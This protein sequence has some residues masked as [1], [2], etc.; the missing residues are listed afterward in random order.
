MTEALLMIGLVAMFLAWVWASGVSDRIRVSHMKAMAEHRE[1]L[2]EHWRLMEVVRSEALDR[3][4]K[5]EALTAELAE[6]NRICR[7]FMEKKDA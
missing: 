4:Q 6:H 1:A 3:A 2:R 7:Q 5:T